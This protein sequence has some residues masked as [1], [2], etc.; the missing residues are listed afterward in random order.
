MTA[1]KLLTVEEAR[2]AWEVAIC[3]DTVLAAETAL[4][5]AVDA[6]VADG[7]AQAPHLDAAITHARHVLVAAVRAAAK[8][9]AFEEAAEDCERDAAAGLSARNH[10]RR[11][12]VKAMAVALRIKAKA[13]ATKEG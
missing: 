7:P 8:R 13:L 4:C 2:A 12:A 9:E 1:P 11:D 5:V 6:R 3:D 10:V